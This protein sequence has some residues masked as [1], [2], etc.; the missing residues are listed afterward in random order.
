MKELAP[1]E[2]ATHT[3]ATLNAFGE[4][5]GRLSLPADAAPRLRIAWAQLRLSFDHACAITS[6]FRHHGPELAGPAFALL[7]PLNEACKRGTWMAFCATDADAQAFIDHD[8]MPKRNLAK[9]IEK[10][11][12][13]DRFPIFTVQ[14][15][16]AWEKF[17]SFTHA[18]NQM[19]G[20]Y[21]MGHGIGAAFPDSDIRTVLDH[22]ETIGSL[23][24]HV[25]AMVAGEFD[26]DLTHSV[27]D[28]LEK[29]PPARV[30]LGMR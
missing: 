28:Q 27:M 30:R 15:V 19:V 7:R 24:V 13:F 25:M 10:H 22:A 29:V 12:P 8:K 18:G 21:T 11:S 14:Y 17:H 9:E 5:A 4:Q 1:S 23:V 6:L 16:K 20:A 3:A 2:Y 26:E